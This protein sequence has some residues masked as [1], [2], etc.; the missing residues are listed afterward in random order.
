MCVC[1]CVKSIFLY[2]LYFLY[3]RVLQ[4]PSSAI[5]YLG[6]PVIG[7]IIIQIHNIINGTTTSAH[8]DMDSTLHDF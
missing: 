7:P 2:F 6:D 8:H 5:Q 1:V 3:I 4:D